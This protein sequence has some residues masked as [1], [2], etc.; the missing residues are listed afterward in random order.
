M[1]A[2]IIYLYTCYI[3]DYIMNKYHICVHVYYVPSYHIS[4]S[5]PLVGWT[6][7]TGRINWMAR[8]LT[9]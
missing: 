9:C 7:P 6:E 8:D 1:Y 3:I 4:S 5:A 2:Y